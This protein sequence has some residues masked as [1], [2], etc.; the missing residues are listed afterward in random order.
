MPL[1]AILHNSYWY[2]LCKISI[3]KVLH[4]W[5]N[6]EKERKGFEVI[7]YIICFIILFMTVGAF[8]GL[9]VVSLMENTKSKIKKWVVGIV[10]AALASGAIIAMCV[11]DRNID[12]EQ[13]NNGICPQC[14]EL[15][16]FKGATRYKN[17]I[18]YFYSCDK[19]QIVIELNS[20]PN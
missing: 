17:H 14:G 6:K 18:S 13:W 10:T 5:Y 1:T 9:M 4:I 8:F 12:M 19:D 7:I 16:E 3:D 20:L 15:W 2:S 11:R